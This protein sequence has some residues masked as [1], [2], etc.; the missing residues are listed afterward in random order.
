MYFHDGEWKKLT[1]FDNVINVKGKEPIKYETYATHHGAVLFPV[2][3]KV[4]PY[5]PKP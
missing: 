3:K 2:S 4:A 1:V 5:L